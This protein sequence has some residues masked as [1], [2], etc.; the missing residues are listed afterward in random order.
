MNHDPTLKILVIGCGGLGSEIIKLVIGMGYSPFIIDFDLVEVSNLNRQFYFT[1]DDTGQFKSKVIATK[2]SCNYKIC[3]VEDLEPDFID[4]FDVMFSCVDSISS[5]MELNYLFTKS[6]SKLLIDCGVE[7]TK[8]HIKKVVRDYVS[9]QIKSSCLYCI[10]E[11]F[12]TDETPYLCSLKNISC[13]ITSKNR[14]KMLLSLI[15]KQKE[16]DFEGKTQSKCPLDYYGEIANNFNQLVPEDLKTNAFEVQGFM[17]KIIPN[18]CWV[19][20]ICASYALILAFEDTNEDFFYFDGE[21]DLELKKLKVE[22]DKNC[23]LCNNT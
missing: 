3:K 6:K 11:L 18:S 14:D 17:E 8:T 7:G 5:R 20:S 13:G 4:D 23:F 9:D 16:S 10:K 1:K 22:K 21:F 19:N 2:K 15:F 12:N